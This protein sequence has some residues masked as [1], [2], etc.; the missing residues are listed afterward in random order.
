M[1]KQWDTPIVPQQ[2]SCPM[3]MAKNG[4]L[5][6]PIVPLLSR[7]LSQSPA[8][9]HCYITHVPQTVPQTVPFLVDAG[10]GCP[11]CPHS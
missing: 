5:G 7:K 8:V 4:G 9:T 1:K 10:G 3:K 2:L 11:I 6:Q